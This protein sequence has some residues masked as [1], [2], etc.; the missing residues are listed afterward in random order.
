MFWVMWSILFLHHGG[1]SY[2]YTLDFN[3]MDDGTLTACTGLNF[4]EAT[5]SITS[6]PYML[7]SYA[8][9]FLEC[10]IKVQPPTFD[11]HFGSPP[12]S[13]PTNWTILYSASRNV[14]FTVD[15]NLLPA[16]SEDNGVSRLCSHI[17]SGPASPKK[18]TITPST[19]NT[20]LIKFIIPQVYGYQPVEETRQPIA[21]IFGTAALAFCMVC[22]IGL[23][24]SL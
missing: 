21:T 13:T 5:N 10:T 18:I 1:T 3:N 7:P 9:Y 20:N 11:L 24:R 17:T 4:L 12:T 2:G 6:A 8:Q 22:V 19:S 16:C 23:M 14:N 15:E